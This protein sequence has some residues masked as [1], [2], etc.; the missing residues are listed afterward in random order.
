MR[1]PYLVAENASKS[2]RSTIVDSF[3]PKFWQDEEPLTP[4][5]LRTVAAMLEEI[6]KLLEA[7]VGHETRR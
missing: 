7:N 6:A 5:K 4:G 2:G 3:D 1:S